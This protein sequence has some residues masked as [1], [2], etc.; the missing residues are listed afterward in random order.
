[1]A[2]TM[3]R[4]RSLAEEEIFDPHGDPLNMRVRG[5]NN[6]Y[7]VLTLL[8]LEGEFLQFRTIE[9]H[10]C[11]LGHPSLEATIKLLAQLNY[12]IRFIK[13]G[14]DPSDGEIVA[15]GDV[16]LSDGDLTQAQFNRMRKSFL[17]HMDLQ[18]LRIDLTIETGEDPGPVDPLGHTGT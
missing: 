14:W 13:F 10:S 18:Y 17:T 2:L 5:L 15:Y 7:R 1:M 12:R 8:E 11:P 3:S 6:S 4:L 9:Y 16:W